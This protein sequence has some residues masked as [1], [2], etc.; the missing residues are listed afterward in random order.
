MTCMD[1]IN[2]QPEVCEIIQSTNST[3]SLF[4]GVFKKAF[5]KYHLLI[6]I[7]IHESITYAHK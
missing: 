3:N 1:I 7:D 4:F 2:S 6:E 5:G